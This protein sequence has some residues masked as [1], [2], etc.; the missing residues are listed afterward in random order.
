M[1]AIMR[2]FQRLIYIEIELFLAACIK[3]QT[4]KLTE[5]SYYFRTRANRRII[6]VFIFLKNAILKLKRLV[7]I[8]KSVHLKQKLCVQMCFSY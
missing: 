6:P 4:R 7:E 8:A 5:R 1:T 2:L 3:T